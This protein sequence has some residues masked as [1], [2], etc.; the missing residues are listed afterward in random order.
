MAQ[1]AADGE[2]GLATRMV[3]KEVEQMAARAERLAGADASAAAEVEGALEDIEASS[4]SIVR[5]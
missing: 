3:Q 1:L 2:G 4:S 5:C